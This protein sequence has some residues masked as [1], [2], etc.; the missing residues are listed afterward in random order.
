MLHLVG[1]VSCTGPSGLGSMEL[2]DGIAF[3]HRR[4]D[5]VRLQSRGWLYLPSSSRRRLWAR[6][7]ARS[8]HGLTPGGN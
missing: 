4:R 2:G 5:S 3:M 7:S 8:C 6:L 1:L